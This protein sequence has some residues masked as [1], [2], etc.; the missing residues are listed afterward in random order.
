MSGSIELDA[1]PAA[2]SLGTTTTVVVTHGGGAG[3]GELAGLV[4]LLSAGLEELPA[5]SS[6]TGTDTLIGIIGGV[7]KQV[8]VNE[9]PGG[10][11]GASFAGGPVFGTTTTFSPP[12]PTNFSA[13]TIA[14]STI[15]TATLEQVT[16][17]PLQ[18]ILPLQGNTNGLACQW[19]TSNSNSATVIALA[20][21]TPLFLE[22]N[23]QAFSAAIVAVGT[24]GIYAVGFS[25]NSGAAEVQLRLYSSNGQTLVSTPTAIPVAS[26]TGWFKAH[27]S[28]GG[29]NLDFYYSPNNVNN[30][31]IGVGDTSYS[32]FGTITGMGVGCDGYQF[33]ATW[34]G[35]S[36]D[37]NVEVDLWQW[38][39]SSP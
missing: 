26:K 31:W 11:G 15:G 27:L 35:G 28:D 20:E 13:G 9:L 21:A 32:V 4:S 25:G 2:T 3:T 29:E 36:E 17:G 37:V 39:Y 5:S 19:Q 7:A 18:V 6:I 24:S 16:G 22:N 1:L 34:G 14:N 23:P 8:A 38:L 10:G 30:N 33:Y 12:G